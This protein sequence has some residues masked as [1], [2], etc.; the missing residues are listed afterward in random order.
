MLVMISVHGGA[1]DAQA[2]SHLEQRVRARLEL[3]WVDCWEGDP[4]RVEALDLMI[5]RS[6]MIIMIIMMIH[7]MTTSMGWEPSI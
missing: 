4:L 5:R 3:G 1:F 2:S 6:I 7:M